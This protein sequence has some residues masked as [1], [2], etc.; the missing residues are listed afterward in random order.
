MTAAETDFSRY[1]STISTATTG[2][3]AT[4]FQ[5]RLPSPWSP[6]ADS[7]RLLLSA[8]LFAG[9]VV[10]VPRLCCAAGDPLAAL[11]SRRCQVRRPPVP[12]T[13]ALHADAVPVCCAPCSYA[14][15]ADVLASGNGGTSGTLPLLSYFQQQPF[16]PASLCC[17]CAQRTMALAALACRRPRHRVLATCSATSPTLAP[18][19][20][21]SHPHCR[22]RCLRLICCVSLLQR[23]R[24]TQQRE[25]G[26]DCW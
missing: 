18:S 15:S 25:A 11:A 20:L 12:V 24:G 5:V 8:C 4:G 7:D 9:H 17:S 2:S 22:L 26:I 1:R 3:A 16:A 6:T 23:P 13:S 14:P 21:C 10:A 19:E